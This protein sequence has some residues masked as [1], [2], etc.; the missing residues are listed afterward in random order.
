M[1]SEDIRHNLGFKLITI[2]VACLA[3]FP[4]VTDAQAKYSG[5]TGEPN[6]PFLI[7]TAEDLN[8][9]GLDPCDWDK[10]FKMIADINLADYT[11]DEFN[12]IKSSSTPFTGV[13]DGNNHS[14]S[15]LTYRETFP[16]PILYRSLD[17]IEEGGNPI[18]LPPDV[19][20]V[21]PD[22]NV[23]IP[24]PTIYGGDGL[25]GYV[26]GVDAEIKN[27]TLIDPNIQTLGGSIGALVGHLHNGTIDNCSVQR[28]IVRDLGGIV[29]FSSHIGGLVGYISDG[30][31]SNCYVSDTQ[32]SW[33]DAAALTARNE[34]GTIFNCY[35]TDSVVTGGSLITGGLVTV[36]SG[37][38][39]NSYATGSESECGLVGTN[40]GTIS[41]C[42]ATGNAQWAG[43]VCANEGTISDSYTEGTVNGNNY[44]GGLVSI[45]RGTISNCYA[46]GAVDGNNYIGGLV[47]YNQ[48]TISGCYSTGY[49]TGDV[50]VGVLVGYDD[51]G[52]YVSCFWDSDVNPDVN[53]IGNTEDPNVIG[54]TT[55]N[56]QTES[57]F[58]DAGWD[59]I[60]PIWKMCIENDYP[61]LWWQEC[62]QF[63]V[64][65]VVEIAPKTLNLYSSGKW[66]TCYIWLPEDCDI[67]DV[68]SYS[69]MLEDEIKAE[70][71]WAAQEK[72]FVMAKFLRLEVRRLLIESG[73]LGE[74]ELIITGELIDGTRFE[75]KDTIK[76]IDK[77]KG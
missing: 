37:V 73:L 41:N 11:G 75:G 29:G 52:Q 62:H 40:F 12:L 24:F 32:L 19:N 25:F 8:S 60:T 47:A 64:E 54:Q 18:I 70:W 68:N 65:A 27:L 55:E 6:D 30:N 1:S 71:I 13:F 51:G 2:F 7:A 66:I 22:I 61:R 9:I 49:V 59:F 74:V 77:A 28:G 50:N 20:I 57:I 42:F 58:T 4:L 35:A 39:L 46:T 38:I 48:G 26:D 33:G 5:G 72:Q 53:G 67:A 17:Y 56:M 15:N 76:V 10:H 34:A 43:L 16:W 63:P 69:I 23:F 44:A 31:V 21:P 3:Y 45:N 36:N 14:I